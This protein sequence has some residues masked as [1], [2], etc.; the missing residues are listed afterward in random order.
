MSDRYETVR[1]LPFSAIASAL[2]IDL[3]RFKSR[4]GKHGPEVYGPCPICKPKQNMTAF[5]YAE[6]GLWHCFSCN[7][8]GKG[9]ID[10]IKA[11]R[12]CG[13]EDAV[14]FLE[15]IRPLPKVETDATGP[16]IAS[17]GVAK[18]LEKDTWRKF[19]VPC[20][21]LEQ[22]IPD[23]Q[24]RELFGVFAYHNPARKSA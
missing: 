6:D 4:K 2:G 9:A 12:A 18:A 22:R 17:D 3:Q 5:S 11:L 10:F 14:A 23:Q 13:F 16:A 21:W 7:E 24:I 20:P 19:Q 8:S 15:V 1:S